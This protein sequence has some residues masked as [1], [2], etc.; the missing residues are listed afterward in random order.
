MSELHSLQKA[1][2]EHLRD[3][4][5]TPVP[6]GLNERRM[7]VYSELIFNNVSALLSDF[8]PVIKSI[9]P[10]DQWRKMVRDFF[11]SHQS[12]TPYFMELSG[13]FVEYLSH[14]QMIGGL[15]GFLVHLAHY[16]WAELALYTMDEDLP[17]ESIPAPELP[18]SPLTLTD[19]AQPL[20]YSFPVHRISKTYQPNTEEATYLLICRSID[21]SVK[22]FELQPLSYQLLHEMQQNPGL[23]PQE[24]LS[25]AA[26]QFDAD[27]IDQFVGNGITLLQSLNEHRMFT[28]G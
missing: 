8:F 12:Q 13:E 2:T 20:A 28:T 1:F 25:E 5:H 17:S 4:D 22:F 11:I 16:E 26:V 14:S 23:I 3:P 18:V 9:L 27:N 6:A 7:S 24:W 15:P 21:E 19:L 10:E